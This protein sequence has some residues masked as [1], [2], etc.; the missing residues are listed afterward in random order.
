MYDGTSA[1][2]TFYAQF[3]NC[4]AYNHWT[5]TDQLAYLKRALQ[6][7]AA[8]SCGTTDQR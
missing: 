4:S 2:E 5:A 7:E 1:F 3:L 8:K 6:K